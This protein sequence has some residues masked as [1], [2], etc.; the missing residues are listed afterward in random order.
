MRTGAIRS[1]LSSESPN[2]GPAKLQVPD[3]TLPGRLL[4]QLLLQV[5]T[6]TLKVLDVSLQDGYRLLELPRGRRT[7]QSE[8][9][10]EQ[11]SNKLSS[12]Q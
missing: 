8:D 5:D 7:P 12:V 11:V 3:Q 9:V 1:P 6:L 2:L 4:V 10:L